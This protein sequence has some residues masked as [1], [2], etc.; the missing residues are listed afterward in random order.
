MATRRFSTRRRTAP[1]RRTV[2]ARERAVASFTSGAPFNALAV[3]LLAGFQARYGADPLGCT[4]YRVRGI[5]ACTST[6]GTGIPLT[7]AMRVGQDR[8][9]SLTDTEQNPDTNGQYL[10]WLM[11]EPFIAGTAA[12]AGQG[13]EVEAR[14][15]D[16]KA[17]RKLQELD[18]TLIL[19]AGSFSATVSTLNVFYN[20][21]MLLALP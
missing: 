6:S 3:D 20:L 9:A 4:L 16:V 15:I 21:S 18:Q 17:R 7:V 11:Y 14:M 8:D 5:I 2:W 13:T 1:R 12:A 10:D 19:N